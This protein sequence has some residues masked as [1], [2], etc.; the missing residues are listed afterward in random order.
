MTTKELFKIL[1]MIGCLGWAAG[2][3]VLYALFLGRG[4]F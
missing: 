3:Y 1:V 4:I 2:F